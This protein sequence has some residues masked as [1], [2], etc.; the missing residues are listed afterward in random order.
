MEIQNTLKAV[1]EAL[2]ALYY[3]DMDAVREQIREELLAEVKDEI[4]QE[5]IDEIRSELSD[6]VDAANEDDAP[7]IGTSE[8]WGK[9]DAA[10]LGAFL[11]FFDQNW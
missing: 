6:A 11:T 7:E 10:G 5:I 9:D 8:A 1:E 3:V 4:R 2:Y